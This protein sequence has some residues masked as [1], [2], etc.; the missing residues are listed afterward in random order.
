VY[1]PFNSN[2]MGFEPTSIMLKNAGA[3]QIYDINTGEVK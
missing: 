1:E 2:G 3:W